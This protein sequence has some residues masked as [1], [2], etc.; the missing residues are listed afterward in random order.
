MNYI[1]GV[2]PASGVL[3]AD[4]E[5]G[6]TGTSP[7]LNHPVTG[8]TAVTPNVWHHAAVTYDGANWQLYLDGSSMRLWRWGSLPVRTVFSM[9][10][11]AR[12]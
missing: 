6:A 3:A 4:F 11:W 8:R 7:G 2:I 1:L 10:P 9:P 5:E 12:R